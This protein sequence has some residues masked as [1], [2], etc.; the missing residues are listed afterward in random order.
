[1]SRRA[2]ETPGRPGAA[3][4]FPDLG[5]PALAGAG[6][7]WGL[8]FFLGGCVAVGYQ[9]STSTLGPGPVAAY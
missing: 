9:G 2:I 8:P 4:R 1:V 3:R 7:D 6:F 5:G